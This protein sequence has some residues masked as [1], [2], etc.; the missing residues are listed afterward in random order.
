MEVAFYIENS[1]SAQVTTHSIEIPEDQ[2]ATALV[3]GIGFDHAMAV[4]KATGA[5]GS[6][7][8]ALK[9]NHKN[10]L[11]GGCLTCARLPTALGGVGRIVGKRVGNPLQVGNLPTSLKL[12]FGDFLRPRLRPEIGILALKSEQAGGNVLRK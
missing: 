5:A 10:S 7:R 4:D 2:L 9:S 3:N 6:L 11:W 1:K 8:I 12:H